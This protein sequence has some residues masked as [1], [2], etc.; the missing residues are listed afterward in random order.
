MN[1]HPP[2]N[3]AGWVCGR[4]LLTTAPQASH[5]P[6]I[7]TAGTW[8]A[9]GNQYRALV[10]GTGCWAPVVGWRTTRLMPS[11]QRWPHAAPARL[12]PAA[13]WLFGARWNR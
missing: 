1:P 4:L 6:R 2:L 11:L 8:D 7:D 13:R 3:R 12:R 5:A 10:F 9:E